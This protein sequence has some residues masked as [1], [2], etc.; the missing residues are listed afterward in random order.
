MTQ[1][2]S[3]E[4][5]KLILDK[6]TGVLPKSLFMGFA[7]GGALMIWVLKMLGLSQ[8]ITVAVPVSCIISYCVLA[9]KI[10]SFFLTEEK[11]GDNAYYLGFLYTLTSLSYALWMFSSG[12]NAP[13]YIIG[14]FGVA[15][16]STI[17]GIAGRVFFSQLRNDPNDIERSARVRV[18]ETASNLAAELHQATVAFNSYTRSL[19]QSVEEAY[20]DLNK[21]MEAQIYESCARINEVSNT[22][23][24]GISKKYDQLDSTIELL[25]KSSNQAVNSFDKMGQNIDL[26]TANIESA[27]TNLAKV[28]NQQAQDTQNVSLSLN[29]MLRDLA[30]LSQKLGELNTNSSG[31]DSLSKNVS[32]LS[33]QIHELLKSYSLGLA[34]VTE[35]QKLLIAKMSEHAN[36]LEKQLERSRQYTNDTHQ[37]L[38][39]MTRNLAEKLG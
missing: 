1:R 19:Q 33:N 31:L 12:N 13:E 21:K 24:D 36:A 4:K 5:K 10:D 35:E 2:I 7:L 11:I 38:A 22:V 17:V 26:S 28:V 32:S 8:F 29:G 14:S 15:L 6:G 37:S 30:A 23:A 20:I 39:Q 18:A 16:W 9:Y 3:R 27:V 34:T 25:V